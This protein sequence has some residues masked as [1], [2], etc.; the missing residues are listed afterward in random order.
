MLTLVN[1]NLFLDMELQPGREAAVQKCVMGADLTE[2]F[3]LGRGNL[4]SGDLPS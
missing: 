3:S 4:Q 2:A 1:V